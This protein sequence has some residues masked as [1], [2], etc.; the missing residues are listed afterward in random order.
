[1]T[2][3]PLVTPTGELLRLPS[4]TTRARHVGER[5]R[6][7]ADRDRPLRPRHHPHLR[8]RWPRDIGRGARTVRRRPHLRSSWA[9]CAGRIGSGRGPAVDAGA[10]QAVEARHLRLRH[11]RAPAA[12]PGP[13][14]RP[15]RPLPGH[16][17]RLR[18]PWPAGLVRPTRRARHPL[19]TNGR[20]AGSRPWTQ[21]EPDV[22]YDEM[23]RGGTRAAAGVAMTNTYDGR[24]KRTET[25]RRC[26]GRRLR[27]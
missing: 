21:P 25:R 26:G 17:H 5:Q 11:G 19:P 20:P 2:T 4:P 22:I 15:P 8:R 27:L 12:G 18:R 3:R 14:T 23:G 9:A 7:R 1:M 24:L 10:P 16:D 6:Q 13:S